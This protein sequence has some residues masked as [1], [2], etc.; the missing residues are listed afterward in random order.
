MKQIKQMKQMNMPEKIILIIAVQ[1]LMQILKLK[2]C[3][4]FKW[5]THAA[6]L[7]DTCSCAHIVSYVSLF[8][9]LNTCL[10]KKNQIK[11]NF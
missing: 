10:D 11:S 9:F 4:N 3:C 1:L 2:D 8:S 7:K 5:A 6:I